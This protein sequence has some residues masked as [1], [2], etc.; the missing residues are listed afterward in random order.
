[1][2]YILFDIGGTKSRVG[3][4]TDLET[5]AT[6][7]S[8]K[9]PSNFTAG[10]KALLAA[11]EKVVDGQEVQ[12]IAGGI[13]G[14]LNEEK[15]GLINDSVLTDWKDKSLVDELR[16]V[17]DVPIFLENDAALAGV[18]EAVYGAGK[19]AEIVVYHTVST[20]VGGVKIENGDIDMSA[21]GFEPGHQIIDIDRTVLGAE[22]QPILENIIS[23]TAIKNRFGVEPY[24]IPQSDVLWDE[25]AG[26]L[27]Q[28]LN[29]TVMYWSPDVIVLGGSMILGDPKI[30][31][32][33]IRKYTVEALDEYVPAPLITLA[34]LGDEAGLYGGMGVLKNRL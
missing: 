16:A 7:V 14:V 17:Y 31:I 18:G 24:E 29:N 4:S 33:Q 1:M 12:A 21:V 23:G 34:K 26:Y 20:G 10:V 32:D 15:T 30:E 13:R 6:H 28:G 25:L 11:I 19:G 3:L 8:F 22:V 9:T 27:A 5:L 2:T